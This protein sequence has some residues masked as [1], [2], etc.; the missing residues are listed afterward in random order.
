[1]HRPDTAFHF[2]KYSEPAPFIQKHSNTQLCGYIRPPLFVNGCDMEINPESSGVC[3]L[4]GRSC[5]MSTCTSLRVAP[6]IRA[7]STSS[8]HSGISCAG[9]GWPDGRVRG[10]SISAIHTR[11]EPGRS[12]RADPRIPDDACNPEIKP[13]KINSIHPVVVGGTSRA[14]CAFG[15]PRHQWLSPHTITKFSTP[16]RGHSAFRRAS[17]RHAPCT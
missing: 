6:A 10:P 9:R 5:R 4:H 2:H 15:A 16:Q 3:V 13:P 17:S 12:E 14:G 1:M 8:A 11:P 7:L